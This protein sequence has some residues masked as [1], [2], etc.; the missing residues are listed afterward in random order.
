MLG[1]NLSAADQSASHILDMPLYGASYSLTA[2]GTTH[3]IGYIL[4]RLTHFFPAADYDAWF[5][6]KPPAFNG[7]VLGHKAKQSMRH[8][9]PVRGPHR[10]CKILYILL[11]T[12]LY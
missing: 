12:E 1:G 8:Q 11:H 6:A 7:C 3:S 9:G 10:A 5:T 2:L 4:R